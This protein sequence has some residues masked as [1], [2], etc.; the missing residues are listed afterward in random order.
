MRSCAGTKI[1][2]FE[3]MSREHFHWDDPLLLDAQLTDEKK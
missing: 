2:V 3:G 1:G